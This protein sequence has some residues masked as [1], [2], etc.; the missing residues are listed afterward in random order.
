VAAKHTAERTS[1]AKLM[2]TPGF[3][4]M[5]H[6]WMTPWFDN[7]RFGRWEEIASTTNPAPD[8]TYV[9][10]IWH[11]AEGVAAAR[12]GRNDD[13]RQH[14][15]AM[16]PLLADPALRKIMVWDRYP[17][18]NAA[19]IAERSLTAEVALLDNDSHAAIAALQEAVSIEDQTPYDEPPAWHSPTRHALGAV[20]LGAGKAAE[21]EAV[22]RAELKR[23]PQNGWSLHGLAMSLRAQQRNAE[24]AEVEK[25]FADAWKNADV[26]LA[27]SQI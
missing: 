12:Q 19:E 7:V 1:D 14:L 3:E 4:A 13:A 5:Q 26:K 17:I 11:Y 20:L 27:S 2:R 21:A 10:V 6:Y 22:Y 9:S 23:N 25:R 18:S 16:R 24:A 15:A 8:L